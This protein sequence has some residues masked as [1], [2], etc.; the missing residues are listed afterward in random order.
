MATRIRLQA[1]LGAWDAAHPNEHRM[2]QRRLAEELCVSEPTVSRW[3]ANQ[4]VP[5]LDQCVAICRVLGCTL[6]DLVEGGPCS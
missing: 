1:M 2:T 5:G 6:G 3:M 4:R